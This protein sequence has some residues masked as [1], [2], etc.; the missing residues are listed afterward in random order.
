MEW[1]REILKYAEVEGLFHPSKMH[2]G[3]LYNFDQLRSF[4]SEAQTE[5]FQYDEFLGRIITVEM[6]LRAVGAAID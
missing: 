2:S 5:R 1:R 3:N 4:L 6:A